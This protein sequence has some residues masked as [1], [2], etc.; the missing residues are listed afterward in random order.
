MQKYLRMSK[1]SST[2]VRFMNK[3]VLSILI[4]FSFSLCSLCARAE[5]ILLRTGARVRGEIVF[6]N[7]EVIIL[8]DAS[9]ARYQ[10]PK[11]E[12]QEILPDDVSQPAQDAVQEIETAPQKKASVLFEL[13]GGAA[14]LPKDSVG[15]AFAVDMLVGSHKI[16]VKHIFVG[17]GV[18]FHGLF[19]G[20]KKYNFLPIQAALR[21]PL[22][23]GK[24]APVFGVSLGYGVAL[25]KDYLGGLYAGLDFGYKY[26]IN[27][28]T[29]I[30]VLAFAQFHQA[31]IYVTENVNDVKYSFLTGRNLVSS[32]LKITF[33][34]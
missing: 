8:S 21:M 5:T 16:G 12:V 20:D 25:S 27:D 29:S 9:G 11:A 7:E 24:H 2:F 30:G 28:K 34:L 31:Q 1:K 13:S 15:G 6:Q 17:A 18:G 10:Y 19:I 22:I 32:G 23:E 33:Y 14:F 4:L 3:T 26:C